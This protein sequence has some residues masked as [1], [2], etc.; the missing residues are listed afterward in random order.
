MKTAGQTERKRKGR[1]RK[2]KMHDGAGSSAWQKEHQMTEEGSVPERQ[3]LFWR[4]TRESGRGRRRV[5]WTLAWA[6]A[7]PGSTPSPPI[8]SLG[9]FRQVSE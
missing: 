2:G 7:D 3:G 1:N 5:V 8:D 9:D 6:L 4:E